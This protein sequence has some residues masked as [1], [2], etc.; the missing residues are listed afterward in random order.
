MY[1]KYEKGQSDSRV[2]ESQSCVCKLYSVKGAID[3]EIVDLTLIIMLTTYNLK[4]L[5]TRADFR[6]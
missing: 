5:E 3:L 6:Y 2:K 4:L 1:K